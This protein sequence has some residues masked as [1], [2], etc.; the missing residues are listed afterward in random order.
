MGWLDDLTVRAQQ[1]L[2][3]AATDIY[4]NLSTRVT[5]QV[6]KV[7]APKDT[8][9]QAAPKPVSIAPAASYSVAETATISAP[10][11]LG[12][13]AVIYFITKKK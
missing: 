8:S 1:D 4:T 5:D 7:T 11:V 6:V 12:I 2:K 10:I 9:T 3:A 13:V